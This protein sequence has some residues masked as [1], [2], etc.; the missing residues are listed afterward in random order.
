MYGLLYY[1]VSDN[2]CKQNSDIVLKRLLLI[3]VEELY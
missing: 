2:D 3:K 1:Q